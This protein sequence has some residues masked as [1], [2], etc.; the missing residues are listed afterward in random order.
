MGILI[1]Q[2]IWKLLPG[3]Y[4]GLPLIH[5]SVLTF[6]GSSQIKLLPFHSYC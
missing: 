2:E 1:C 5:I 6:Y 4:L 3:D